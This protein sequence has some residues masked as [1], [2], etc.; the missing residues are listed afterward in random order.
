MQNISN[1]K[2]ALTDWGRDVF[3]SV[4]RRNRRI[5]NR[6]GGIQC[7]I[8]DGNNNMFLTRLENQLQ[9]ELNSLLCQEEILWHQRSRAAWLG[10]GDRNTRFYHTKTINI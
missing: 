7:N 8:A 5:L 4:T 1:M 2:R 9:K 6:L 3:G 10:D